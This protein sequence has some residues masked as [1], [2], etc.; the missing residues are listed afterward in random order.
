MSLQHYDIQPLFATPYMRADLSHA[1]TPD[2]VSYVHG[3]KMILNRQNLISEDLYIFEHPEL[4][5]LGAAVQEALDVYA[6]DILGISQKL[7]VTQ[8]WALENPINVGM[9]S[10]AHSNSLVSGSLYYDVLPE[11]VS[12]VFFD[13][14]TMYQQIELLPGDDKRNLYNTPVN[15][16]TP[17]SGEVLLFPSD[18]NHMI[19]ANQSSEPRRAIAFNCFVK[20]V[21]G[22][23][24][25][26]SQLK[27]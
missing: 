22:D 12:R 3:L 18:I 19:E 20:G 10:H 9:H 8:S 25:D 14:H 23:Y 6:K 11:P 27:L 26:V 4:Q 7:Y 16:I 13:R 1:L 24:R 2:V 5:A 15:V 21:I 17:K